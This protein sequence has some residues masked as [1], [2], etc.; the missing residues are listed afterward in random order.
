MEMI[1]LRRD[2]TTDVGILAAGT[3]LPAVPSLEDGWVVE[4]S[5]P[6]SHRGVPPHPFELAAHMAEHGRHLLNQRAAQ[7]DYQH[8]RDVLGMG[9]ESALAWIQHG[10][11]VSERQLFRWGLSG[12]ELGEAS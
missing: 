2:V 4:L 7:Y 8:A 1:T 6:H 10:Y 5:L 3:M 9:H 12:K 11:G